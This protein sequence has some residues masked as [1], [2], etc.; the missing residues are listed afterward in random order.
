M[1]CSAGECVV[2]CISVSCSAGDCVVVCIS[3]SS[4]A[5][6]VA[7]AINVSY[8]EGD[9]DATYKDS[10][11][12]KY[13]RVLRANIGIEFLLRLHPLRT[14][15]SRIDICSNLFIKFSKFAI[16]P[17]Y[18]MQYVTIL[19]VV[20]IHARVLEKC[21]PYALIFSSV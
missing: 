20:S 6:N 4:S 13:Q 16:M 17:F 15:A 1:S 3:V 7:C 14:I 9:S 8:S 10:F 18:M 12:Y 11:M 2:V 19:Q 5:G 21:T